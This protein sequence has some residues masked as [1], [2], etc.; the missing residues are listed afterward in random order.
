MDWGTKA[1]VSEK[2]FQ[3]VKVLSVG[4]SQWLL[5]VGDHL[6]SSKSRFMKESLLKSKMRTQRDL[7]NT[8]WNWAGQSWGNTRNNTF[9]WMTDWHALLPWMTTPHQAGKKFDTSAKGFTGICNLIAL[10]VLIYVTYNIHACDLS[11]INMSETQA[12]RKEKIHD[13]VYIYI[14]LHCF[15]IIIDHEFNT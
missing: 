11:R 4:L 6:G 13:C 1:K 7:R 9:V 5:V 10:N 15:I 3:R 8:R 2:H 14:T 12:M